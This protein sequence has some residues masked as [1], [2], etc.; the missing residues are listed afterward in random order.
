MID[1]IN[2]FVGRFGTSICLD[3]NSLLK[4]Q[5]RLFL[6]D[7][8]LKTLVSEDFLYAGTYLGKTENG[9]FLPSLSLL[10]MMAE[11]KTNKVV[12]DR[13]TEWLFIC[14]RDIFKQ[15][16]IRVQGSKRKGDYTLVLNRHRE[17]L[18]FGEVLRYLTR[19]KEGA[20]IRNIFDIGDFLRRER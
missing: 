2:D 17:C 20:V 10:R 13:K 14:G 8:N 7:K 15:G 18:G 16:V 3:E 4:K 1:V 9:K 19:E 5:N 12:V 11:K 6:V